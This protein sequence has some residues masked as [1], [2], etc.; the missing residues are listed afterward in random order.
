M[1]N[2]A[3]FLICLVLFVGSA[4]MLH[5]S[6]DVDAMTFVGSAACIS[7]H[8]DE[9]KSWKGSHH[10]MAMQH[11]IDQSVL[12][13]FNDHTFTF[14]GKPNRFFRK[15]KA[16]WVNIEGPDGTFHDYQISFTFGY[17]PLQQ[18]MVEFPDGRVQLIPF[19]WDSRPK[20]EGG[21]RWFHL[22]PDQ[23][24]THKEFYWMNTGQNWNYM[25]A[26]CHSTNLKKN[27]NP[28]TNS[29]ATTY[30]EINVACEACHGPGSRHI[31]WSAKQDPTA[32]KGFDRNL[33]K[34]V[35]QWVPIK[36]KSTLQPEHIYE[37]DQTLVCAQCHSRHLQISDQ[38][39]VQTGALGDRYLL[40]LINAQRYYPD[41]QVYDENYVYG[42]FLQS[43]M[44][45]MG[46]VCTDCHDPHTAE[47][48]VVEET[49]CLQ[50]HDADTYS[51]Q[52]HHH[53][54]IG[55]EGAQC[56]NCHMPETTYMQID[57]RRDHRWHIPRPDLAIATGSP[58]TCIGCHQDKDSAWS[59]SL[60]QA[61]YGQKIPQEEKHFA[62]VFS[63]VDQGYPGLES[64]LSHIAQNYEHADIIRASALERMAG[65]T[66]QNALIAI[67]RAVRQDDEH[68]RVGAVRGAENL[69]EPDRWRLLS[70]LLKDPVLSVRT[71]TVRVLASLWQ[72]LSSEQKDQLKPAL[73]EYL[74]IQDYNSDRGFGHTN[75]GIIYTYQGNLIEAEKSYR[76]A[77]R[78]EPYFANAYVNL[79]DLY[80]QQ[81][82]ENESLALLAEGNSHIPDNGPLLFGLGLAQ[83]RQKENQKAADYLKLATVAEPQNAHYH[84]VYSLSV[85]K[86]DIKEAIKSMR[87]AYDISNNPAHL[88]ALCDMQI[89][90]KQFGASKCINELNGK[91][92][93]QYIQDLKMRLGNQ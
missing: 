63:A 68:I 15:G 42:S 57:E 33:D 67:A 6:Q 55:S 50:C 53:H 75:K 23:T 44:N 1:I 82:R 9:Y 76:D 38:D 80:R 60:T 89:R 62:P 30:S 48:K 20:S 3:L 37:S 65:N 31:E 25:C 85:E 45:Q 43:K 40:S 10:F 4:N 79:A 78:I 54:K 17:E 73:N 93:G 21:Q 56:M 69:P 90:H 2:K 11:A 22:Y 14:A 84:Y 88:Y 52:A 66:D 8:Q 5:A 36:G 46:V 35:N 29:Y 27:F 58:D 24:E 41:G 59:L 64:A 12:G 16:F 81:G 61:W 77:I 70:P 19:A 71:E 91:I 51:Q 28:D 7:C 92:P 74:A 86:L 32:E 13:D 72:Q 49:V 83:V 39:H 18:Y 87:G 26:D 34:R 47:L